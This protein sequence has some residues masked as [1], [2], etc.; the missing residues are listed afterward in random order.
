MCLLVINPIQERHDLTAV[1]GVLG[2]ELGLA[3]AGGDAVLHRP[4]HSLIVE[5]LAADVGEIVCV[6]GG[7]GL[8]LSSPQEGDDLSTGTLGVWLEGGLGGTGG[9]AVLHSP[10][11]GLVVVA[12]FPNVG[13]G[14]LCGGGLGASG[15]TPQEGYNLPTG[16]VTLG[17]E[18]G[19]GGT[20]GNAVIQ[21]PEHG[22]VIELAL[23]YIHKGHCQ[24]CHLLG[25]AVTAILTGEGLLTGG[26]IFGRSG[27]LALIV[28]VSGS[29]HIGILVAVAASG[30]GVSRI[31]LF[32]TGGCSHRILIAVARCA[33][34][35]I[36]I[37]VSAHRASV[38]GVALFGASRRCDCGFI[39]MTKGR[40]FLG[41][42]LAAI[43]TGKGL[44][45]GLG[46]GGLSSH[47][48]VIIAVRNRR[49][50]LR[51]CCAARR[52]GVC[53]DSIFVLSS[54]SSH[55]TS[56]P[57]MSLSRHI[58]VLITVSTNRTSMG[59]VATLSTG[60]FCDHIL[61]A[62]ALGIR[63]GILVAVTASG[64]CMG[65]VATLSTGGFCDHI[66]IA[67]ALGI[68]VSVLI[69]VTASGACMGSV[70]SCG[71]SGG[72]D[73]CRVTVTSLRDGF[74][75]C[76]LASRT[77]ISP[78]SIFR[79][80]SRLSHS[81]GVPAVALGIGVGVLVAISTTTFVYCITLYSTGRCH[82]CI[83]ITV[84]MGRN[85]ERNIL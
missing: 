55:N 56:V 5:A 38:G 14:M 74:R 72:C 31:A 66:L 49:N 20:G 16:A 50:N 62:V 52:T 83:C 39:A 67:V 73:S 17:S 13:E 4:E 63:V 9:D 12:L 60:G 58:C 40:N 71:T 76:C 22:S 27:D 68:G 80:G 85:L 81:T 54:G 61:I 37:V 10:E 44:D 45:T 51:P 64:A 7:S 41:V 57:S 69:A 28:A 59:G 70:S 75:L 6:T 19:L 33:D 23:L 3:G 47:N 32:S 18:G 8:A 29:L 34:I 78:Y 65:G 42:G 84:N 43:A 21:C 1:A 2:G 48:A 35:S 30:A 24:L 26:H 36:L 25:V 77:S 82:H 15:S 46:A 79:T 11:H 53:S